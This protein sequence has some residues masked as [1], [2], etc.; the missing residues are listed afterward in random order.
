MCEIIGLQTQINAPRSLSHPHS[1]R[2]GLIPAPNLPQ[3]VIMAWK[4][5]TGQTVGNI[6]SISMIRTASNQNIRVLPLWLR[7][8]S[9]T[10]PLIKVIKARG[11]FPSSWVF[12]SGDRSLPTRISACPN[13]LG[14]R[15]LKPKM[16]LSKKKGLINNPKVTPRSLSQPGEDQIWRKIITR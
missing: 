8:P 11:K 15:Y 4:K 9:A 16:I 1:D 5:I 13:I 2:S 14:G 12:P 3:I 10:T 6:Q 7:S